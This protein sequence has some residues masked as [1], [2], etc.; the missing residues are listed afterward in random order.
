MFPHRCYNSECSRLVP[1]HSCS[2]GWIEHLRSGF[3]ILAGSQGD[4]EDG[5]A[6]VLP[7]EAAE[8]EGLK[9]VYGCPLLLYPGCFWKH[10]SML[11]HHTSSVHMGRCTA[12]LA[13][14]L[15]RTRQ[16]LSSLIQLREGYWEQ[17]E[18]KLYVMV[19]P[20]VGHLFPQ[21]DFPRGPRHP[22]DIH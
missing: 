22:R 21:K 15:L 14:A 19:L 18:G 12:C 17:P 16:E 5:E 3:E 11:A 6:N 7:S 9:G 20:E 8:A 13:Q 4:R 10:A 1:P 2:Q